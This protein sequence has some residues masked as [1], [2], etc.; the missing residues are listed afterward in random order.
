[1]SIHYACVLPHPP[2]ILPEI[3]CGEEYKIQQ[4]IDAYQI[5]ANHIARI[6]PETIVLVTP[7]APMFRDGFFLAQGT[8]DTGDMGRFNTAQLSYAYPI[9]EEFTNALI[10]HNTDM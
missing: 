8:E 3:G 5:I 10:E 7:H 1:M 4:T 2:L 6:K 9:D